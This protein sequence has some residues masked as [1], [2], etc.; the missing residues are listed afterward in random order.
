MCDIRA[1]TRVGSDAGA[2]GMVQ[3]GTDKERLLAASG[4]RGTWTNQTYTGMRGIWRLYRYGTIRLK[5][6]LK[7]LIWLLISPKCIYF[8]VAWW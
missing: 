7:G 2:R 8:S 3:G 4:G 5:D 6:S 1:L